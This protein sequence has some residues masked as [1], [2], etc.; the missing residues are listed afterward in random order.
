MQIFAVQ[1]APAF[2]AGRPLLPAAE[3]SSD[4][5]YEIIIILHLQLFTRVAEAPPFLLT[6]TPE[7]GER[8]R[9]PFH[10]ALPFPS[11]RA[12]AAPP[13]PGRAPRFLPARPTAAGR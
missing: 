9:P 13:A 1:A 10:A 5:I 6:P 7:A 11:R 4:A 2:P 3:N 8:S 12:A